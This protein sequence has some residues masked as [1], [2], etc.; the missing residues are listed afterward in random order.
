[1]ATLSIPDP[2]FKRLQENAQARRQSVD[3]YLDE[4]ISKD[5]VNAV[6]AARQLEAWNAFVA[7]MTAFTRDLPEGHVTDDSRES[8]YEGRGE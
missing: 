8:I 1:M 4:V 3:A 7:R 6:D 5:R 2:L